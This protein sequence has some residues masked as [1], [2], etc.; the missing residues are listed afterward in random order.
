MTR[1]AA[2]RLYISFTSHPAFAV[3]S[4]VNRTLVSQVT[5]HVTKEIVV[6][7]IRLLARLGV[8]VIVGVSLTGCVIRPLWWGDHDGGHRRGDH[9]DYGSDRDRGGPG[10]GRWRDD[11]RR[12]R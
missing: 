8:A 7:L 4:E 2:D 1:E 5:L 12:G 6:K 10:D 11:S 9:R 3:N